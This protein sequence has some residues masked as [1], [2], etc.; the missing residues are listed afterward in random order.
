MTIKT[1][2]QKLFIFYSIAG[3]LIFTMIS[4][5]GCSASRNF[6]NNTVQVVVSIDQKITL[7]GQPVQIA[8]LASKLKSIGA[9]PNTIIRVLIHKN[10][11]TE[12]MKDISRSLASGGYRKMV[13]TQPKQAEVFSK[14]PSN[15]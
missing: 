3:C 5:Q 15:K 2:L 12:M 14:E 8:D 1:K 7:E 13:F 11:S 4:T 10:T 6:P 9:T